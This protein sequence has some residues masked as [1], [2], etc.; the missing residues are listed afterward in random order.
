MQFYLQS[1]YLFRGWVGGVGMR[2]YVAISPTVLMNLNAYMYDYQQTY[3]PKHM[4]L[5]FIFFLYMHAGA[6]PVIFQKR[7]G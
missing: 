4:N 6:D 3:L 2:G 5:T 1:V 7:R